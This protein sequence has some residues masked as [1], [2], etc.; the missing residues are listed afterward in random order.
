MYYADNQ[1]ILFMHVACHL[2]LLYK[3]ASNSIM[4]S[5][6]ICLK[7]HSIRLWDH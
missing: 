1:S 4:Q 6:R 5:Y 2:P 3:S 7:I